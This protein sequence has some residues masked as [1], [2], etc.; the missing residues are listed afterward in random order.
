MGI[1]G[2]FSPL[3]MLAST[4][5]RS[6]GAGMFAASRVKAGQARPFLLNTRDRVLVEASPVVALALKGAMHTA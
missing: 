6:A 4:S 5:S 1:N 3:A 2:K